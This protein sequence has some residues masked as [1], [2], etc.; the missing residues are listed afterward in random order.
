LFAS[1]ERLFSAFA[2]VVFSAP[3]ALV[4]LWMLW[5]L[6]AWCHFHATTI[7]K[8]SFPGLA[9][10]QRKAPRLFVRSRSRALSHV[11]VFALVMPLLFVPLRYLAYRIEGP[12]IGLWHWLLVPVPMLFLLIWLV[13]RIRR[14]PDWDRDS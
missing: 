1:S 9:L 14:M 8:R 13:A 11:F 5:R 10:E 7:L 2:Y 6:M 12:Q 3:A 4:L